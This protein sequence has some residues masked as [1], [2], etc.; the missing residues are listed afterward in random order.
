MSTLF[1][2]CLAREHFLAIVDSLFVRIDQPEYIIFL[3]LGF[4][5]YNKARIMSINNAVE[6]DSFLQEEQSI[7]LGKF[8]T[9]VDKIAGKH[10]NSVRYQ[11]EVIVLEQKTYQ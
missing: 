9:I 5:V 10:K 7:H 6:L 1:S 4:L 11:F 2:A 8:L 3:L